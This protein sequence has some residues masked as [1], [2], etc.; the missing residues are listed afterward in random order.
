MYYV[1]MYKCNKSEKQVRDKEKK[2]KK[3]EMKARLRGSGG[4][5]EEVSV[6]RK[7]T[8]PRWIQEVSSSQRLSKKVRML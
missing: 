4:G 8:V 6:G 7:A 5:G 1:G 2:R 3:I